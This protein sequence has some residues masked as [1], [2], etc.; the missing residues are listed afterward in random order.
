MGFA[1]AGAPR[2]AVAVIVENAGGGGQVSAPIARR[3][4]DYLLEGEYPSEEDIEAVQQGIGTTPRGK[5]VRVE[6]VSWP[7]G[8]AL[9]PDDMP[10]QDLAS[11][12]A[13]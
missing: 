5:P 8:M 11:A 4:F 1:P 6:D 10:A 12:R 9:H 3:I 7:D 13:H 2:V